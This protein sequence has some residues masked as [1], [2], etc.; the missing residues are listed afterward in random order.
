M[1]L[2]KDS[3]S[4]YFLGD[5][6]SGMWDLNTLDTVI[7]KLQFINDG[8]NCPDCNEYIYKTHQ[9][10]PVLVRDLAVFGQLVY[11]R[12]IISLLI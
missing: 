6:N 9:T 7:L 5:R 4:N 10:R 8:I 3:C 12:E 1:L 2:D 11:L